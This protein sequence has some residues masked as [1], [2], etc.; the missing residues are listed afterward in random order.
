MASQD[1]I[2]EN[3]YPSHILKSFSEKLFRI[4]P[5]RIWPTGAVKRCA[6]GAT[7]RAATRTL[8]NTTAWAATGAT[9]MAATGTTAGAVTVSGRHG[10]TGPKKAAEN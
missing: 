6:P 1:T 5:V 3:R 9:A 4:W 8:T 7:A 2:S 10:A